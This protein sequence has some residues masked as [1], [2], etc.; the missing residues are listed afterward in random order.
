MRQA[1]AHIAEL[2][3]PTDDDGAAVGAA[4]TVALCGHWEHEPPCPLAPHHSHADREGT[5][6]RVRTLF[7]AE[8]DQEPEV[9]RLIEQALRGG[10]QR[11]P[12]G[13]ITRWQLRRSE[14][15]EVSPDELAHAER[16]IASS[17]EP[18]AGNAGE[19]V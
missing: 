19:P 18:A 1:F 5:T 13:S 12:D 9:R 3:M 17:G 11:R 8:P 6:V 10:E 4:I 7:A 14:A 2:S 16:L 15:A